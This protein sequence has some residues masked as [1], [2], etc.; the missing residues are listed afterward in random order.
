[1]TSTPKGDPDPSPAPTR[2]P[3]PRFIARLVRRLRAALK[4]APP[5]EPDWRAVLLRE[6]E[7]KCPPSAFRRVAGELRAA[8]DAAGADAISSRGVGVHPGDLWLAMEHAVIA[9]SLG[10]PSAVRS[11]WRRVIDLGGDQSPAKAFKNLAD[12]YL[13]QGD[14]KNAEDLVRRGMALYPEDFYLEE[15]L[16][17]ISLA[18]GFHARAVAQGLELIERHPDAHGPAVHHRISMSFCAEGLFQRAEEILA[19]GIL[20]F[21]DDASLSEA[22]ATLRPAAPPGGTDAEH[23]TAHL[24]RD[25][26]EPFGKGRVSLPISLAEGHQSIPAMLD[27]AECIAPLRDPRQAVEVDVFATLN[28][29]DAHGQNLARRLAAGSGKPLLCIEG[30]FLGSHR[31]GGDHAQSIIISPDSPY[32]DATRPS[33]LESRLNSDDYHLTGLQTSRTTSCAADIV[34]QRLSRYN[35]APRRELGEI[36]PASGRK[37]ILL[38]DQPLTDESVDMGLGGARSFERMCE[39][40]LAIPDHDIIVRLHPAAMAGGQ[41]SYLGRALP[42]PLPSHVTLVDFEVNPFRLFEVVDRVFVCTSRWGFEALLAGREVDCFAV[43]FYAGWGLTTDHV[44]IPRRKRRRSLEEI[45]HLLYLEHSRYFVPGRGVCEIEDLIRHLA[46][47]AA[48]PSPSVPELAP[49][50]L[51]SAA[52]LRILI[53]L[54]SGRQAASG[55]YIQ[56]LAWSLCRLDCEVMVLAEG[57]CPPTENGVSWHSLAFEGVRLAASVREAVTAFMPDIVY[58]NGVRT[59]AQRA[60]LEIMVLTGARLA[61]QSEDDDVQVY[62]THHGKAAAEILPLVDKPQLALNDI[63][64]YLAAIDLNHS[65]SVLLDPC[66][67]RWVEPVT[68]A[69]CYRLASLHTAIWYPFEARLGREYEVPTLVVPPVASAADFERLP[70]TAGERAGILNR[71]GIEPHRVVFFIGGSLYSYSDEYAAF[72]DALNQVAAKPGR[73]IA[74]VVSSAR[75]SLPV[76][77]MARER[78]LPEI[79][80]VD[81]GR[82]TDGDYMEML[83]ACDVVCSPGL[84]DSFNRF[85]LPSRLVKAMAMAKPVL[86]CRQGFGESLEHGV[87][88]FLMDGTEPSDWADSIALSLDGEKRTDVGNAGQDFARRHFDSD[89][90]AGRLKSG[91]VALMARPARCLADGITLSRPR[92]GSAGLATLRATPSLNLRG[93]HHSTMQGAILAVAAESTDLDTVVHL[94]AGHCNEFEDYCR[95]G[96]GKVLLVEALAEPV[97]ALRELEDGDGRVSVVQAV[98]AGA[99]GSNTAFIVRNA[100]ADS[101]AHD[102]LWLSRP[103]RLL[104]CMPALRIIRDCPVTITTIAEVCE[105][106]DLTAANNLLVLELNGGEAAALAAS[107]PTL[108]RGFRWIALRACDPPLCDGGTTRDE[109]HRILLSAGFEPV[110][111]PPDHAEPGALL[112]FRRPPS[113]EAQAPVV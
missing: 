55:R 62:E 39:A 64:R 27:F 1:M 19:E 87:N 38:V 26:V 90:V 74:L 93:R 58:E 111:T 77:R 75:S 24:F 25:R 21:P 89:R 60:A 9:A 67:D 41:G 15:R 45:F 44:V 94:G 83:K 112:L 106:T 100:R 53:I 42:D 73:S 85:R 92:A 79:A 14:F 91:F 10:E 34:R 97:A 109:V 20:K 105:G 28:G 48:H 68:R 66:H 18:A 5:V 86:T 88:A 70:P 46:E 82:A 12:C 78:L 63:T 7:R 103:C 107:P 36:L 17:K 56:N 113:D 61:M 50:A 72:L 110:A 47:P 54:P 101:E 30:G 108:L 6:D 95:L 81:I 80:F 23:F 43:P 102:Q 84:P 51:A 98:I 52:P 40:A 8:G 65:L 32:F 31:G 2:P 99:S 29:T 13:A 96:A 22:L 35:D 57:K 59:R 11:R 33:F 49:A 4:P 37:R 76:A 16:G 69:L 3:I 71:K 104:E